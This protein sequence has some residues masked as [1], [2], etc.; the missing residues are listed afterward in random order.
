M[1]N[2]GI[3]RRSTDWVWQAVLLGTAAALGIWLWL[4]WGDG[5]QV[6]LAATVL[7]AT[8]VLAI[9]WQLR[10][11]AANRLQNAVDVFAEREMAR[12]RRGKMA[13]S[14]V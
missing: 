9:V 7:T 8:A 14:A 12:A 10:A 6:M 1:G 13:R 4:A 3:G 11:R 5:V 2:N